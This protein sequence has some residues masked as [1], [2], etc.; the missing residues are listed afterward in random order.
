MIEEKKVT[1]IMPFYNCEAFLDESISSILN[2]T[3]RDFEFIIINDAS[4]D[5]S[6]A[7][8]KKYLTDTRIKYIVNKSNQGITKNLNMALGMAFTEIIA[9]MDGDDVAMNQRLQEQY[10]FLLA[11]PDISFV[12]SFVKIINEQGIQT[13]QRTKLTNPEEIR[14]TAI[15]YNPLVHPAVMF[16]KSAVEGLG[17][18]SLDYSRAQDMHLWL[19]AIYSGYRISNV[20]KYLLSYRFHSLSTVHDA[21]KNALNDFRLRQAVVK[22]FG[23][24]L[25]MKQRIH[26]F[27]QFFVGY[28]LTGNQRRWLE[29]VYKKIFYAEKK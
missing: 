13:D 14:K 29:G 9:R 28:V 5:D 22:E 19:R 4:T 11:H 27:L 6:D 23:V 18:Y 15:Y 10:D 3:F 17:G 12:G 25:T 1:V 24:K 20:P 8:V 2:Q 26:V 21:K 16:R 7:I